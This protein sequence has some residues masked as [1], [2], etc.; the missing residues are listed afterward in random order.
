MDKFTDKEIK[1]IRNLITQAV[2]IEP[3][4]GKESKE[5]IDFCTGI[6]QKMELSRQNGES[7]TAVES[8]HINGIADATGCI[9]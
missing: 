7:N 8:G 1:F 2:R 4:G 9:D 3:L 5:Q 6:I